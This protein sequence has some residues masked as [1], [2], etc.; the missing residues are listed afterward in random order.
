MIVEGK[1]KKFWEERRMRE[2]KRKD[3]ER[4][5]EEKLRNRDMKAVIT[6]GTP[7]FWKK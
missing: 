6:V 3:L 4:E 5:R 1:K 2:R 7:L